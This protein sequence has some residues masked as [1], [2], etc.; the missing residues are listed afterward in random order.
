MIVLLTALMG[1]LLIGVSYLCSVGWYFVY[2]LL[3]NAQI[4]PEVPK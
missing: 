1:Q 4:L 3:L 2:I